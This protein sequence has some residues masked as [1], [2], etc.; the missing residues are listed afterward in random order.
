MTEV[1]EKTFAEDRVAKQKDIR[2]GDTEFTTEKLAKPIKSRAERSSDLTVN[3][4][5]REQIISVTRN[6]FNLCIYTHARAPVH[7]ISMNI[8]IRSVSRGGSRALSFA[9]DENEHH[10]NGRSSSSHKSARSNTSFLTSASERLSNDEEEISRKQKRKRDANSFKSR[11]ECSEPSRRFNDREV[12][13]DEDRTNVRAPGDTAPFNGPR[14]DRSSRPERCIACIYAQKYDKKNI[15]K[16]D[17]A[18]LDE[19]EQRAV[20]QE[21]MELIN[22]HYSRGTSNRELVKMVHKFYNTEIRK[23]W[24]YGEWSRRSIWEHIMH[25]SNDDKVQSNEMRSNLMFQIEALREHAWRKRLV[26]SDDGDFCGA[27]TYIADTECDLIDMCSDASRKKRG[28]ATSLNIAPADVR[29]VTEPDH[30]VIR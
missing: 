6:E 9:R 27:K 3:A 12:L 30:R 5:L 13:Q 28:K 24:D 29:L 22:T 4:A 18:D 25:H 1:V 17:L 16:E 14:C 10:E 8:E 19:N 7:T 21:M 11:S 26:S 2:K 20:Y 23:H 15:E